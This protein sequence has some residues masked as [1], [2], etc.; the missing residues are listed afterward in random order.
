MARSG[1]L[2]VYSRFLP[3]F[4]GIF[5]TQGKKENFTQGMFVAHKV[6]LTQTLENL[7]KS[8]NLENIQMNATK[9]KINL[10]ASVN[11]IL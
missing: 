1:T 6:R 4:L 11:C 5:R 3:I 7:K 9:P 10:K 2:L 8:E